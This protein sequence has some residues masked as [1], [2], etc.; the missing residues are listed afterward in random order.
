MVHC[1]DRSNPPSPAPPLVLGTL[2]PHFISGKFSRLLARTQGENFQAMLL[3]WQ[4]IPCPNNGLPRAGVGREQ[5]G[6]VL[7]GPWVGTPPPPPRS[8]G[9]AL[10]NVPFIPCPPLF[11]PMMEHDGM[12]ARRGARVLPLCPGLGPGRLTS[13]SNLICCRSQPTQIAFVGLKNW[14]WSSDFQ[15]VAPQ[16]PVV[17]PSVD[18]GRVSR[19]TGAREGK[20]RRV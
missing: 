8:L 20:E 10:Q 9:R 2:L 5:P 18:G 16:P 1:Q 7:E 11:D 6:W 19:G 3:C 14:S 12:S 17:S 13:P 4:L 15:P